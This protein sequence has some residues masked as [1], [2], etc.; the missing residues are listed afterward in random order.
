MLQHSRGDEG[1]HSAGWVTGRLAL[2]HDAAPDIG[3][4]GIDGQQPLLEAEGDATVDKSLMFFLCSLCCG[5][6]KE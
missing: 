4:I 5:P 1:V 2:P 3:R 6:S